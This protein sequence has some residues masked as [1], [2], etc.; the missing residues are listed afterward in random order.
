MLGLGGKGNSPLRISKIS[1]REK[2]KNVEFEISIVLYLAQTNHTYL[3]FPH[4]IFPLFI[5]QP[6]P[7]LSLIPIPPSSRKLVFHTSFFGKKK[8]KSAPTSSNPSPARCGEAFHP[9][10][11]KGFYLSVFLSIYSSIHRVYYIL[12]PPPQSQYPDS[13]PRGRVGG[14][15]F[16]LRWE[17]RSFGMNELN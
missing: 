2:K 6:Q 8:K 5:S 17:R 3:P 7:P 10:E 14:G 12:P 16:S 9:H 15:S 4:R 1:S 13:T 11:R